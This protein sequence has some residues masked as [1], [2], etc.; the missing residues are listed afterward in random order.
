MLLRL[1]HILLLCCFVFLP[2]CDPQEQ[3]PAQPAVDMTF[4]TYRIGLLPEHNIFE[5]KKRYDPLLT[6]LSEQLGVKFQSVILP[7]YGN[8]IKNFHQLNLDGAFF[9]SFTGAMAIKSLNVEPL[10]RPQYLSGASSYYGMVFVKKGSKIRTAEDLRN[11]RMVFVDRATMAGY[12]LPL[13]YFKSIGI[14]DY[15]TWF[16][17]YYF[18]GTHEDA[19]HDVLNGIADVGAAKNTVFYR[20]AEADN[21]IVEELEILK[22]SPHVPANGLAMVKDIPE[23]L[24]HKLQE[25]L[26]T[27]HLR[28]A[29]RPVLE[30]LGIDR[31]IST[32]EIDYQP[33]F[34]Y[35]K[36]IGLDLSNYEYTND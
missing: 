20:L 6:Y 30:G 25:A 12:L 1:S 4:Q 16:S 7:R 13:S 33:V 27:M 8:A 14:D 21:R 2:G 31:F 26:L 5:Q 32:T 24:K 36:E 28:S 17:E 29:G 35:A 34:D 19:I 23:D 15:S 11:K 9:G 18:S 22:T 10:A 3:P